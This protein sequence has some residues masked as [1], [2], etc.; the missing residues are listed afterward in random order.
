MFKGWLLTNEDD[1]FKCALTEIDEKDL[2]EGEVTI[3]V[4]HS[5]INYKDGLAITNAGMIVR[6]W[7]M[8]PGIDIA[9]TVSESGTPDFKVGDTV[10]V[11]GWGLSETHWG[12]LAEKAR[13]PAHM[14]VKLPSSFTTE[15]AM[16][17]GT[18][19]YT[20]MLC[21]LALEKQGVKPAD[22][23][24]IVTGAA[25][26]VGSIAVAVLGKLG[27]EVH[28]STGR[29]EEEAY[30]KGL[31]AHAIVD[32]NTLSEKGKPLQ[33]ETWAGAV[34]TVGSHTLANVIAQTKKYGTVTCVGLA[35][36][37]DLPV[38]VMPFILRSVKLVGCESVTA[39]QALR[40]E[41]WDRLATDLDAGKLAEMSK[42]VGMGDVE[43]VAKDI[44][45]GK[46]RGR[47]VVDING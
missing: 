19:G 25:G 31:G 26:G 47:V 28:A 16:A 44:L 7:P 34:D 37:P 43:Q 3:D 46:V 1:T 45:A 8:V 21:V 12:G 24:I 42:T 10:V 18:A 23:P 4:A 13:V 39:P 14:P 15:Q 17:V 35:Q 2:P 36:G 22:G 33:R 11:N 20:A 27:Y 5:T 6:N 40:Q 41:C 32:R 38:T 29:P 30:L 9:G